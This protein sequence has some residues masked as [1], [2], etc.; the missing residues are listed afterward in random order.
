M[1]QCPREV[2]M[3]AVDAAMRYYFN[4]DDWIAARGKEFPGLRRT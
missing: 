3:A 2:Q 4:S 1:D